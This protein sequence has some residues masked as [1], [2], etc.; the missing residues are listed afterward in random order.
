LVSS[1]IQPNEAILVGQRIRELLIAAR[2]AAPA[3]KPS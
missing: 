3:T 2:K 1:T